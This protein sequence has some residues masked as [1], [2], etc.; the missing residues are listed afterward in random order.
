MVKNTKTWIS[1][2]RNETFLRNKKILNL[3][4]IWHILRSYCFLVGW[5][6][7]KCFGHCCLR[8]GEG[9]GYY[10]GDVDEI[11]F[12]K[13]PGNFRFLILS[14]K[15]SDKRKVPPW[16]L[17]KVVLYLLEILRPKTKSNENS[18]CFLDHPYLEVPCCFYLIN[19]W[20]LYWPFPQYPWKLHII[21]PSCLDIFLNKPNK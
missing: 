2:E 3:C 13:T 17:C 18:T 14:L 4:L 10:I 1:S 15:I 20:K 11:L 9:R 6:L 5:S 21:T 19:V 16:K 8:W 12:E 7:M